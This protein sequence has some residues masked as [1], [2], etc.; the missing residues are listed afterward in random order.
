MEIFAKTQPDSNER[1]FGN[2]HEYLNE[3]IPQF[4]G[5]NI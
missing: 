5:S 3:H 4:A 2:Q 1:F